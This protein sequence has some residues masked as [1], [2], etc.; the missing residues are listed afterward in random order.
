MNPST[1]MLGD[2]SGASAVEFAIVAPV[3][4]MILFTMIGYGIYFSAA[5]SVEQ[6]A[7]DAARYSVAG[8]TQDERSALAQDYIAT[9]TLDDPL[10]ERSR[11]DVKVGPDPAAPQQF[12]VSLSYD[13]SALPIWNL[14]SF[15]LPSTRIERF[16]TIRIGGA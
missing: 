13:A 6:M 16:A 5:L 11:L 4:I 7:A 10:I 2:E 1:K 14:F 15:T 9:V 3:F 12:T 8:L